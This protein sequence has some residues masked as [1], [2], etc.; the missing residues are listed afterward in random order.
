M[1]TLILAA[2]I[3]GVLVIATL[4]VV[5]FVK[6]ESIPAKTIQASGPTCGVSG[7]CSATCSHSST[8]EGCGC[9]ASCGCS[10]ADGCGC[11]G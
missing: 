7:G 1:K 5:N 6:A 2:I 8:S 10:G 11:K 4:G 3:V 9:G